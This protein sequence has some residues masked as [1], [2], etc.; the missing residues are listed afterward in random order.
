MK[1]ITGT[2]GVTPASNWVKPTG[3]DGE[4][5]YKKWKEMLK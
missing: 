2:I 1:H 5:P 3:K 4:N